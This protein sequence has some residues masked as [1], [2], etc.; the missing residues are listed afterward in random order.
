MPYFRP[1][2]VKDRERAL[3]LVR[4]ALMHIDEKGYVHSDVKWRNLGQ[5][6]DGEK[7][8][9]YDLDIHKKTDSD[10]NWID[11][12]CNSLQTSM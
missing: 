6:P 2:E 3:P 5:S 11:T 10:V 9:L 7:I 4:T 12:A 8:V 1:V